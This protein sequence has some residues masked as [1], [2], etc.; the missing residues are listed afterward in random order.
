MIAR[1]RFIDSDTKSPDSSNS[2]RPVVV[3]RTQNSVQILRRIS[4]ALSSQ[5]R[6]HCW[7][8]I[9]ASFPTSF[10]ADLRRGLLLSVGFAVAVVVAVAVPAAVLVVPL[11]VEVEES[12]PR[13]PPL[14]LV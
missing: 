3:Y 4:T 6:L 1:L 2:M 10:E 5:C 13:K 7:A 9:R 12:F 8:E 14:R 11:V